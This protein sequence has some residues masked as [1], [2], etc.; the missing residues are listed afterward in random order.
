[1]ETKSIISKKVVITAFVTAVVTGVACATVMG[2][3]GDTGNGILT[4]IG[5]TLF[6]LL[7]MFGFLWLVR[8]GEKFYQQAYMIEKNAKQATTHEELEKCWDDL[9]TLNE[10]SFHHEMHSRIREI[11]TLITTKANYVE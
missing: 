6:M 4:A 9:K 10:K 11:K 3:T 7:V 1:M 2:K 8:Q 5:V